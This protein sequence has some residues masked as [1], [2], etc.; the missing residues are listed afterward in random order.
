MLQAIVS[1]ALGS[2]GH[3]EGPLPPPV[4]S[5]YLN[6]YLHL[7]DSMSLETPVAFFVFNRPDVTQRVFAQIAKA[8][9]R[10]LLVVCDGPRA[11]LAAEAEQVAAVR[12]IID[13][14][15]WSCDVLR[16]YSDTNLG[17]KQRIATGLEW[18]F[19]K[20]E[21]AIILEDDCLPDSSF[22][23]F[24]QQLL[25][26]YRHDDRVAAISGDNFQ[27]QNVCQEDSYYFSKYFHCWGWA[28]WRRAWRDFDVNMSA[29]PDF[30]DTGQLRN[31]CETMFETW[32]W[33]QIFENVHRGN[34]DTWDV[35]WLFGCLSRQQYTVIPAKNLV[36]NVGFGAAGTHTTTSDSPL[37]NIPTESLTD[38]RHPQSVARNRAADISTFNNVLCPATKW[39]SLRRWVKHFVRANVRSLAAYIP[40]RK[41]IR[42]VYPPD[43]T[44]DRSCE[45]ER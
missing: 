36:S 43:P 7:A 6:S 13:Q 26:K 15:D 32:Y 18:V 23:P 2:T 12:T 19:S 4:T 21:E 10:K 45:A 5:S 8:R 27:S 11:H 40:P 42:G 37:A 17:C 16:N 9:P 3:E 30:R 34:V 35:Q 24:C 44:V 1:A 33:A 14:V 28:S 29:W 41:S 22:F 39:N 20:F 31:V 25:R 38:I